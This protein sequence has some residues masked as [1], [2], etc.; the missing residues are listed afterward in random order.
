M[1]RMII[2]TIKTMSSVEMPVYVDDTPRTGLTLICDED[3]VP[4][5]KGALY[6]DGKDM[7]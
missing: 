4:F 5:C 3:I 6:P 7:L 2:V 1:I